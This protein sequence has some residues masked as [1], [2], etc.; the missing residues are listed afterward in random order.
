MNTLYPMLTYTHIKRF[1][2]EEYTAMRLKNLTV[3]QRISFGFAF[4]FMLFVGVAT[5]GYLTMGRVGRELTAYSSSTAETNLAA[6]LESSMLALRMNVKELIVSG[7][8]E[9]ANAHA[10]CYKNLDTVLAIA[11][12]QIADSGRADESSQAKVLLEPYNEA[13]TNVMDELIAP[14]VAASQEQRQ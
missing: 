9:A 6:N 13:F 5:I 10:C 1:N 12:Q 2:V 7:S 8:D 4:V 11:T 3:G 14:I